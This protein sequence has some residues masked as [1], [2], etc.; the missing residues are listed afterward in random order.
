M[1]DYQGA[2]IPPL[3]VTLMLLM[4]WKWVFSATEMNLLLDLS[5]ISSTIS[6]IDILLM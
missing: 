4:F 3:A 6:D 1:D 5:V 2:K